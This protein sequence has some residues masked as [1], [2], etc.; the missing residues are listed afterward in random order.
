[1]TWQQQML[2]ETFFK[3]NYNLFHKCFL[4]ITLIRIVIIL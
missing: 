3:K 2:E 4:Y 1:M